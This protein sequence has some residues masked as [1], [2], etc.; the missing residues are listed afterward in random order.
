MSDHC[1][2]SWAIKCNYAN[3]NQPNDLVKKRLC[4]AV[5][6]WDTNSI[7]NYQKAMASWNVTSQIKTFMDVSLKLNETDN[8]KAVEI[9]TDIYLEAAKVSLKKTVKEKKRKNHKRWFNPDLQ[10]LK[11]EVLRLSR[12]LQDNPNIP[13]TRSQFFKTL[14]LYTKEW[15][16]ASRKYKEKLVAK[17]EQLKTNNP[18][19]LVQEPAH[20]YL[21]F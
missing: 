9:V 12:H 11:R 21:C 10:T 13:E 4:P 17:L 18:Q 3:I 14:K 2:I 8:E 6:K 20:F 15:E 1:C 16:K 5:Y 7:V 19:A